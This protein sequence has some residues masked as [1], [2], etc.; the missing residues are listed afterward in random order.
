MT[1]AATAASA[2]TPSLRR[3]LAAF[4]YEGVLLFGVVVIAGLLYAALTQQRHALQGQT[5]LQAVLFIVIGLYF[6]VFWTRGGQTVAMR[7]WQ[8]RLVA[9]DGQPVRA[10]RALARY[11]ASWLWFLPALLAARVAGL[12]SAFEVF[13]LLTVGAIAYALLAFAHPQRQFWHDALCGTRLVQW[14]AQSAA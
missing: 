8:V 13:G 14:R 9:A 10:W 4:V 2:P 11:L 5:G 3:R 12:Q 6:I 1:V 7:A